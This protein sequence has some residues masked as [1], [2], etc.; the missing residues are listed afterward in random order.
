MTLTRVILDTNIWSSIGDEEATAH[1]DQLMKSRNLQVVVSPST[2]M[3]VALLPVPE[4]RQRIIRAL[5]TGPRMRLCTEAEAEAE[6]REVSLEVRRARPHWMRRMPDTAKVWALNNYWTKKVW[7]EALQDSQRIY[8]YQM[9]YKERMHEYL[10]DRQRVRRA[11][12]IET[13]FKIRPLTALQATPD[14][15]VPESYLA[16]WS[17]EPVEIWRIMLRDYYWFQ[18]TALAGRA[19]L[20]K[21]DTT[22]ADWVG[23]YV[24]LVKLRESREDFTNFGSMM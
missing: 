7:R 24:N 15:D 10:L 16:G 2:L 4:A 18:L 21:E 3:E 13:D 11:S 23:S 22:A 17:G 20:T 19:L 14:P 9:K 8:D 5:G 1:F 6:C 12:F